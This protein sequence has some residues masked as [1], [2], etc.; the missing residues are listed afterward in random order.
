MP[1]VLEKQ[2]IVQV[3]SDKFDYDFILNK[4]PFFDVL[5]R[6]GTLITLHDVYI[7]ALLG[8]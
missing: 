4:V 6:F 3:L 7:S 5:S 8:L 1:L 2:V